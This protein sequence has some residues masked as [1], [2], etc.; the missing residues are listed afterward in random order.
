MVKMKFLQIICLFVFTFSFPIFSH[1]NNMILANYARDLMRQRE[2]LEAEKAYEHLL[3]QDPRNPDFLYNL[4]VINYYLNE[5]EKAKQLFD[6]CIELNKDDL[7]TRLF[8]GYIFQ[9]EENFGEAKAQWEYILENDPDHND[10]KIALSKLENSITIPQRAENFLKQGKYE[11]AEKDYEYLLSQNPNNRDYLYNLGVINYRLNKNEKAKYY[12]IK[13]VELNKD[14]LD[15]RLFLGY[16]F[17]REKNFDEAR[18]QWE[19][20]IE[21]DPSYRDAKIALNNLENIET[22]PKYAENLMNQGEYEEAEKAYEQLLSQN[23]NN[24]EFLYNLGVINYRLNRNDKAKKY[25]IKCIELN[26]DDLDARY[27][28]G[29]IYLQEDK[30]DEAKEQFQYVINKHPTYY[31]AKVS[32][33]RIYEKE[34]NI[35]D[36][37]QAYD[38]VLL[39]NPTN[40]EALDFRS[41][42]QLRQEYYNLGL[43]DLQKIHEINP[44]N[45]LK[46][47]IIAL[48]PLVNPSIYTQTGYSEETEEDLVLLIRTVRLKTWFS[49]FLL[50]YPITNYLRTFGGFNYSQNEQ[51]NIQ[52]GADNYKYNSYDQRVGLESYFLNHWYIRVESKFLWA[53][54][55]GVNVFPFSTPTIWQPSAVFRFSTP[56]HIL[57]TSGY[58]DSFVARN[59]NNITSYLVRRK[60][61]LLGYEYRYLLPFSGV[62][63]EGSLGWYDAFMKNRKKE[64]KIWLRYQLPFEK[65][66]F[67]IAYN[68][69]WGSYDLVDPDYYSYR[70]Q[71]KHDGKFTWLHLWEGQ[72][73]FEFIYT[74]TWLKERDFV[75]IAED[76]TTTVD[77]P[78]Q[79]NKNIYRANTVEL[80]L[81]KYFRTNVE[82]EGDFLYY[83]NTNNYLA[84][85]GRL[86][87]NLLF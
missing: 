67:I 82:L 12:F 80:K 14:D 16:I 13:C 23:P 49:D 72:G 51:Y 20:V 5:N 68:G 73:S 19:Y 76:I 57:W 40:L 58:K 64:F 42:A 33:A 48:K 27:F 54:N 4:G 21:K 30:I 45:A 52:L 78:Q 15:A 47:Q 87:L 85:A 62:G 66:N 34:G 79:L 11:E 65:T 59:F 31:D 32:L 74:F 10:A 39:E 84:Y 77:T 69:R 75:N 9:R 37:V 8:L 2:Y 3:L 83:N 43:K 44:T 7:D 1:E 60:V 53:R 22:A 36:A 35:V 18:S 70:W 61:F 55:T 50:Q 6:K 81:K 86:R 41:K 26:K 17:Q 24:R 28:L 38:Q 63:I 71:W 29:N 56:Q 25:F 46:A